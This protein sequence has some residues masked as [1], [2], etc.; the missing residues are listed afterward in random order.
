MKPDPEA[1]RP[2]RETPGPFPDAEPHWWLTIL[3]HPDIERIG[4][5]CHLRV[6]PEALVIGRRVPEFVTIEGEATD[7]GDPHVSRTAVTLRAASGEENAEIWELDRPSGASRLRVEG[8]DCAERLR[9]TRSA[10]CD[11]V[12]L[13]LGD[14]VMLHLR[15]AGAPPA[16]SEDRAVAA[17]RGV[18]PAT[19]AL[20]QAVLA[21]GRTGDDVLLAGPT[22]SGKE[23][24]AK[25]LH[26]AGPSSTG[27]WIPVNMAAIPADLAAASLFGV[28]RGAFTGADSNRPGYFQQ[29]QGGTL[30][31]DEIG[32]APQALQP[33]LLRAL[34]EREIQVVGGRSEAVS[35]RVIAAMERDPDDPSFPFRGA[36]RH[37]LGRQELRLPALTERR[38]DIGLLFAGFWNKLNG[39]PAKVWPPVRTDCSRWIRLLE[40]FCAYPWPGNVRELEHSVGQIAAASRNSG[41]CVPEAL[42]ARLQR[43]DGNGRRLGPRTVDRDGDSVDAAAHHTDFKSRRSSLP[44]RVAENPSIEFPAP[45]R[46]AD[47]DEAGLYEEWVSAGCEVAELS[48]RL[49]V[50]RSSVY[51]RLESS[52]R[53]RLAADVP[54]GELL[55]ALD[56]CRG[57]LG[58][59]AERLAVSRRGLEARMRASGAAIPPGPPDNPS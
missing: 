7:L 30:F 56:T 34:Q 48:R 52:K 42:L 31:L 44:S 28:R 27:P 21:A 24:V 17:L 45:P 39:E 36:L 38:E 11:G 49:G 9:F 1:T 46:L 4:A 20:R 22:G 35:V 32:D 6:R 5:V 8:D 2:F 59:T 58:A 16:P 10:L 19:A 51:R 3:W 18:S 25:A 47:L 40:S 26:E 12:V 37:R 41:L 13:V 33:L 57:D 53:C 23:L 15:L 55:K 29:A 43:A 50:S 14:H 54:L